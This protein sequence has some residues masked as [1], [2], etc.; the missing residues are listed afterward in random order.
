M[1]AWTAIAQLLQQQQPLTGTYSVSD[2]TARF[3]SMVPGNT[4][5]LTPAIKMGLSPRVSNEQFQRAGQYAEQTGNAKPVAE[6]PSPLGSEFDFYN[7]SASR[8]MDLQRLGYGQL[9]P[10]IMKRL[11]TLM[12]GAR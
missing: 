11:T 10:E 9:D 6:L 1:D 8:R 5:W 7:P 12:Q 2:D 3:P 4:Q